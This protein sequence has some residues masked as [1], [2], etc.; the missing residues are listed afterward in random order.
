MGYARPYAPTGTKRNDDDDDD[1]DDDDGL[2][3]LYL[4][5]ASYLCCDMH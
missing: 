4:Y 2:C 1:D 5:Q 3:R